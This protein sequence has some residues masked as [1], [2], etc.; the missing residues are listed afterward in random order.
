[1]ILARSLQ[2]AAIAFV[3]GCSVYDGMKSM[4]KNTA[5]MNRT[6]REMRDS[7]E[8]LNSKTSQMSAD[9]QIMRRST[10][11]MAETT[12]AMHS[13]TTGLK[14][15]STELDRQTG[16]LYQD[17]R[18]GTSLELRLNVLEQMNQANKQFAKIKYANFYFKS[19][20]FQLW[21][22]AGR[23]NDER[24]DTLQL[25]AV[26]EVI[27][28]IDEL[29]PE[30]A[31]TL[32]PLSNSNR[33]QNLYALSAAL[34]VLN[35][36]EHLPDP[37]GKSEHH[38]LDL[39]L[40][41]ESHEPTGVLELL[42]DALKAKKSLEDGTLEPE[43]LKPYQASVLKFEEIATYILR[44]RV[45]F[46]TAITVKQL[47][48]EDGES[49]NLIKRMKMWLRP[50]QP[51]VD[52]RNT[53]QLRYYGWVLSEAKATRDNLQSLG[54]DAPLDPMLQRVMGHIDFGPSSKS[55]SSEK[56]SVVKDLQA[57]LTALSK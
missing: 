7:T 1:M 49:L 20:E 4:E 52:V 12:Q 45:N 38:G 15:I 57:K 44:L 25:E 55:S 54:I 9:T 34:H 28:T 27:Q 17:A 53:V 26:Q 3:S 32:S 37:S 35:H 13:E 30:G 41:G 6:T 48:S 10:E 36:V 24:L 19:L 50:W 23:D 33:M 29:S 42:F 11:N 21:K 22:D 31:R 8:A 2:V 39:D 56:N 5:E 46:L 16:D 40:E 47:A 18:Q 51:K 43:H 14:K